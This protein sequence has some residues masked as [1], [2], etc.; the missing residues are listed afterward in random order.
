MLF[1]MPIDTN[2]KQFLSNR[3]STKLKSMTAPAPTGHE[4]SEILKTAARV[5][6]HGKLS[7]FYFIVF[8][9]DSRAE[10]GKIL[11]AAWAKDHVDATDEHLDHEENR[12]MRAP[13]VVAVISDHQK[14]LPGNKS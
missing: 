11:R 7:P 6:D 5:P 1:P 3:R 12:M 10:F 13:L 9:G 4:L 14:F 2:L 8:E